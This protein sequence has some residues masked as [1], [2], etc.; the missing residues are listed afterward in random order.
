MAAQS[1]RL[2][3]VRP[4]YV[5][6][7]VAGELERFIRDGEFRPGDVL[8]PE[9]TLCEQLGVSRPSLREALRMLEL[10]GLVETR[11]GGPNVVGEF[12]FGLLTEW[13]GRATPPTSHSL[14]D[15][16][17]VREALEVGAVKLAAVRMGEPEF[18]QLEEI[19][20]RTEEKVA[21]DEEVLDEDI[22]FHDVIFRASANTVLCLLVDVISVLLRDLRNRV[23]KGA[24]GGQ[25]MLRDHRAILAALRSRDPVAAEEA[26]LDH[27]KGAHHLA[28]EL[29]RGG[30]SDA[31]GP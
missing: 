12:N 29:I 15:L 19:L 10:V 30:S 21:R 5:Y 8:P 6:Q 7:E 16:L 14:F 22:Q 2:N 24:G 11:R 27:L 18:A 28:A 25:S 3:A 4:T 26:L 23:L 17:A 31:G 20:Q 1:L 13:I 9:R